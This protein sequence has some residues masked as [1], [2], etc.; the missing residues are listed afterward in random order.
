M[1]STFFF[2]LRKSLLKYLVILARYVTAGWMPSWR[3]NL[4]ATRFCLCDECNKDFLKKKNFLPPPPVS[5]W[6]A[7]QAQVIISPRPYSV[8]YEV[9]CIHYF[10]SSSVRSPLGG[11]TNDWQQGLSE[12]AL[13]SA[14]VIPRR[15]S[16]LLEAELTGNMSLF[17]C[18]ATKKK[19]VLKVSQGLRLAEYS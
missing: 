9:D 19:N 13:V 1:F 7:A 3:A 8:K 14:V 11:I 16:T 12:D 6:K 2:F 18:S 17:L 15:N 5:K 10:C 4:R